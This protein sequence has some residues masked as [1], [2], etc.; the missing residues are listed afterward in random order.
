MPVENVTHDVRELIMVKMDNEG[1][2]IQW[3]SDK[4]GI[5]YNTLHSLIKRK[6]FSMSQENL[7]KINEALEENFTINGTPKG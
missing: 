7:N 2:T 6:L 1:R 4:T 3:L 5:N